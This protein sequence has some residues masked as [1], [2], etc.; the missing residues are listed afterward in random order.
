MKVYGRNRL[1]C[2]AFYVRCKAALIPGTSIGSAVEFSPAPPVRVPLSGG[3]TA[4]TNDSFNPDVRL[5]VPQEVRNKLMPHNQ[6]VRTGSRETTLPAYHHPG[7]SLFEAIAY[8]ARSNSPSRAG[9]MML[10]PEHGDRTLLSL[11]FFVPW[12]AVVLDWEQRKTFT[13]CSASSLKRCRSPKR[14]CHHIHEE[15]R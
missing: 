1:C 6:G 14:I 8:A 2:C 13:R 3:P 11:P 15:A 9:A 7:I 12:P 5:L 4:G 10:T